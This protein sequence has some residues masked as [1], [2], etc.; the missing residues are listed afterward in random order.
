MSYAKDLGEASAIRR[1]IGDVPELTMR[2]GTHVRFVAPGSVTN[3][4]YGLF[5][6]NMGPHGGGPDAHFHRTFSESFYI[7][8]GTVALFDWYS[9]AIRQAG[10]FRL[11]AR[12][13][14]PRFPHHQR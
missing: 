6:W 7:T 8:L 4:R 10:R 2:S 1:V 12:G 13:R 11:R 5:E 14:Y 9:V 3:E